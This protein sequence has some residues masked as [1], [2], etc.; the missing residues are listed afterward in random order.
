MAIPAIALFF[1]L[2]WLAAPRSMATA[3]EDIVQA[4]LD[5][6][7]RLDATEATFQSTRDDNA[8]LN[9]LLAQTTS[10]GGRTAPPPPVM[11]SLVD[12]RLIGKPAVFAGTQ[13]SWTDWSFVFKA[14]CSALSTRLVALM[15]AAQ[16]Q[17]ALIMP[18]D[19]A[20]QAISAQLYYALA[21]SCKERALEKLRAAPIGNGL[22]IW[23]LF[24]EEWEPRQRMRFT[25][26]LTSIL[27]IELK[28]P[29]ISSLEVWERAI[30]EYEQQSG[31][32]VS[33]A[34]KASVLSS[35][36]VNARIR[37]HLALNASR[38]PDY[39]S[40]REEVVKIVQAQK[41]WT[42]IDG[43]PTTEPMEVDAL[44]KG[45]GK[46]KNKSKDKGKNK[47][48]DKGAYKGKHMEKG[49]HGMSDE[50]RETRTCHYCHKPGHLAAACKKKAKDE[51]RDK[52]PTAALTDSAGSS[53]MPP[54]S[55][56]INSLGLYS[57]G[58][59]AAAAAI[60]AQQALD[61][62][63]AD[64][65]MNIYS[66]CGPEGPEDAPWPDTDDQR[67]A[68]P[69]LLVNA[70][71]GAD[72]SDIWALY[73]SGSGLTTCP[74]HMF[75]DI[76]LEKGSRPCTLE[77]ATGDAVLPIGKRRVAF[78]DEAGE[79]L[80]IAF[81]VTNVTKGIISADAMIDKGY[82]ATLAADGSY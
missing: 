15:E 38:L 40:V 19:P 41:R 60:L 42:T 22:E 56:T 37:E 44:G 72:P 24:C 8:R 46:G 63:R 52:R 57:S 66:V 20:D 54:T 3:Q 34:I 36:I 81:T 21:L 14:Y 47:S 64:H 71:P 48:K 65:P 82:V 12:T 39:K 13:E 68:C 67:W 18:T 51:G 70:I 6:R 7:L 30:R 17:P 25:A 10:V 11:S 58:D 59:F 73:D 45:K 1:A 23:R 55:T 69:L 50:Q 80:D 29:I 43:E 79:A 28:D 4:I 74:Q 5:M 9:T 49:T 61:H 77:A 31:D 32:D 75:Q 78:S 16:G 26:M 76:V 33:D 35:S 62:R 27:R 53:S 2:H